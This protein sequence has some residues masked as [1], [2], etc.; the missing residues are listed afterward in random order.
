MQTQDRDEI[1]CGVPQGA[2]ACCQ[3]VAR[4]HD[5][6]RHASLIGARLRVLE[7]QKLLQSAMC[8]R[9]PCIHLPPVCG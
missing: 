1:K 6:E 2:D 7:H 9:L 8:Q 4:M 5:V 3:H